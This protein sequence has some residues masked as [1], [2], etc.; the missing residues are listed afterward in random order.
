[1][2]VYTDVLRLEQVLQGLV[3]NSI[4]YTNEGIIN[5]GYKI[6][7]DKLVFFVSDTGRGT[8]EEEREKVFERFYQSDYM[9]SGT[10]LGLS[11][12][13]A[14]LEKLSG[15]IWFESELNVGTTFYFSIPIV[16]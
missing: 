14:I 7:K 3:D 10:G 4:K 8:A 13:K 11:I 12:V 2:F 9:S 6:E 16:E 1:V 5:F 15:E